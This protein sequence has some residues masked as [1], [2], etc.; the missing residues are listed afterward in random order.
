MRVLIGCERFGVLRDLFLKAGH[1]AWSCDLHPSETFGPHLQKDVRTVLDASWDLFIC[2]PDCTYLSVSGMHWTTRGFRDPSLTRNAIHFAE[3]LW[4]APIPRICVENP[5]SVLSTRSLLGKPTQIV[6][7]YMFGDDASKKTCL[8]LKN[9]PRLVIDPAKFVPPRIVDG[10]KRWGNQTD[11]G[12]NRLGPSAG[13]AME[14]A[15]TY[16]GIAEAMVDQW[17]KLTSLAASTGSSS[18]S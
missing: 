3:H 12:Q 4:N 8:W 10:Y 14:R 7:P 5:V 17:G 9:L 11:S 1:D 6:Q 15:K 16:P 2:H 13:R 18:G